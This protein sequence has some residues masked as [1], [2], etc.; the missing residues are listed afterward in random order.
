MSATF[1]TALFLS[2]SILLNSCGSSSGDEQDEASSETNRPP[3]DTLVVV[4]SIGVLAGD[5]C[6]MFGEIVDA[7]PMSDGGVAVLD[8]INGRV[9]VYDGEGEHLLSLGGMG[10][11]PGEFQYPNQLAVLPSGKIVVAEMLLGKISVFDEA[12]EYETSWAFDEYGVFQFDMQPFDD[13]TLVFYNFSMHPTG[14]GLS[15]RFDLSRYAADTGQ[16]LEDFVDFEGEADPSTDFIPGYIC[17]ATDHAGRLYLSRC[18]A[19]SWT[20]ERMGAQGPVDSIQ[21]FEERQRVALESDTADVPGAYIVGY[22][23]SQSDGT[24]ERMYTNRPEKHPFISRLACGPDGNLWARRGGSGQQV[25]DVV[26]P[27][28]DWEG[29]CRVPAADAMSDPQMEIGP[30]GVVLFD[31]DPMDCPVLYILDRAGD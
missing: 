3:E 18:G 29:V 20:V 23:Y 15:V 24:Q 11:A 9:R 1:R 6:Y 19:E 22:M 25:W 16:P 30:G 28:G 27:D 7:F 2:A 10:E 17:F 14:G 4:D 5:S 31:W 12:G 26:S 21:L 8:G 13:S